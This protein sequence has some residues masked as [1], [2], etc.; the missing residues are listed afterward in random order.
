MFDYFYFQT[1]FQRQPIPRSHS[2][3]HATT[4]QNQATGKTKNTETNSATTGGNGSG[5]SGAK[6]SKRSKLSDVAEQQEDKE[7]LKKEKAIEKE[8]NTKGRFLRVRLFFLR[9]LNP[10]PADKS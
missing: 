6:K 3:S 4:Q 10:C 5:T 8:T 1:S 9:D 7:D 2:P